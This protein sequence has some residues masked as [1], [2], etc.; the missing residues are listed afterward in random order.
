M[1][2]T[3]QVIT[4]VR[5]DGSDA[6]GTRTVAYKIADESIVSG[7]LLTVESNHFCVLKSRGRCSMSMKQGNMPSKRRTSR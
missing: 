3:R 5:S 6:L 1:A 7:S 4:T 2:I